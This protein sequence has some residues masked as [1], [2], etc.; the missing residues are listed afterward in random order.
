M[1]GECSFQKQEVRNNDVNFMGSRFP[2][3]STYNHSLVNIK[4]FALGFAW[5]SRCFLLFNNLILLEGSPT[6]KTVPGSLHVW[7]CALSKA[8]K[9]TFFVHLPILN[10]STPSLY[11]YDSTSDM[12]LRFCFRKLKA[13]LQCLLPA[14]SSP[15]AHFQ[16][17]RVTTNDL[18][19]GEHEK[20]Q[21][22]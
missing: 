7:S 4:S 12:V 14:A 21:Q 17:T 22:H 10:D 16:N 13:F 15:F 18:V 8:Y 19:F 5:T 2:S 9:A 11:E 3:R 20:Q 1:R 6:S